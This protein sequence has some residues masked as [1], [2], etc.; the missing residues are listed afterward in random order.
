MVLLTNIFMPAARLRCIIGH[1][2]TLL[3]I[4]GYFLALTLGTGILGCTGPRTSAPPANAAELSDE[5]FH[6]YLTEV[7]VVTVDEAYRAMLILADGEDTSANFEE[8]R[9]KL[10][11]RGIA[12][13]AWKLQPENVIDIGSVAFMV[14]RICQIHGGINMR[15][16]GS[17]GLSDRRYAMR[18]LIYR[19]MLSDTVDY[20]YMSGSALAALMRKADEVMEKKGLYESPGVELSDERDRDEQGNLIVPPP[21]KPPN[22]PNQPQ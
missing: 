14:C 3:R 4:L 15:L 22:R 21:V 13:A 16:F 12:R 2:P 18:E 20:D 5:G 9:Q 10:E 8:R 17:W 19:E 7:D 6:A 1:Q 11:D